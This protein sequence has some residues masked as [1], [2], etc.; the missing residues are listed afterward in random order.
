MKKTFITMSVFFILLGYNNCSNQGLESYVLSTAENSSTSPSDNNSSSTPADDDSPS[1]SSKG[2]I[3][4]NSVNQVSSNSFKILGSGFSLKKQ[5]SAILYDHGSEALENGILNTYHKSLPDM[6]KIQRIDE[7]PNTLWHKPSLGSTDSVNTG[8]RI[9]KSRPGRYPGDEAHYYAKGNN[10]FLGWP[11]AYGGFETNSNSK[12]VYTAFWIK[13]PFDL[14]NYY[15]IP[16]DSA[17]TRF[18]QNGDEEYGEYIQIE[19][20]KE[21]GRIIAH[22]NIGSIPEGWLFFEPPRVKGRPSMAGKK[23]TG[24][25]SGAE[26]T[27]PLNSSKSKFDGRGFL[28]PRGKYLRLWSSGDGNGYRYSIANLGVAGTGGTIWANTFEYNNLI[29]QQWNFMEVAIDLGDSELNRNPSLNVWINGKMYL[30]SGPEWVEGMKKA[31]ATKTGDHGLTIALLGINDFMPVPFSL[32]LDDI[33]LDNSF[34]RVLLCN[35]AQLSEIRDK[36]GH[37]E[38]QKI[39]LWNDSTIEFNLYLGALKSADKKFLY[40]FDENGNSNSNGF[41]IKDL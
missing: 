16:A 18:I 31:E 3:N 12:R 26:V 5:H 1:S 4:I 28:S 21:P 35:K 8:M 24:L 17:Q 37:C 15:A 30:Q 34:H 6:H 40:L 38:V 7:D 27:F 22:K 11:S 36:T 33:Y 10:N 39:N 2:E 23:I 32:D 14:Q 41:E 19:G 20:I 13:L 25:T 9:S 29:P